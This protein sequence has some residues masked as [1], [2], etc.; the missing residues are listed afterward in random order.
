[1]TILPH[2]Y[3]MLLIDRILE[4][5]PM[6]Y[7]RGYKNITANEPMFTGHFPGNP[8]LPGVYMIEALAQ[9]GGTTVLE[10]GDMARKLVYLAG[11][12]Q[13]EVPASGR[14]GRPA[15]HGS[16]RGAHAPQRRLGGGRSDGRRQGR[17]QR[18]ADVLDRRR[19]RRASRTTRRSCISDSVIHPSAIVH[20][21]ANIARGVEIGP[22]C[23]VGEHVTIGAGLEAA[24]ARRRQR[25]H[26]DRRRGDRPPVRVDRRAPRR[27]ARP[28]NEVVVHDDRQPHDHPRVRLDPSRHGSG[29][30]DRRSATIACCSRT[31]TSRTTARSATT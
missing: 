4:L 28:T 2:R 27:T 9:L 6:K 20:P 5:E 8:V 1:M 7:A 16:A 23:V 22:Y 12:R 19:R 18:R 26:H 14:A 15:R 24:R 21:A 25:P 31:L 30:H 29:Q 13:G 3:P 11:D 10:P 17:V